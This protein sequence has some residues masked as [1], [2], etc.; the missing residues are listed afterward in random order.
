MQFNDE[1][2]MSFHWARR[3][4]DIYKRLTH[5]LEVAPNYSLY[6]AFKEHHNIDYYKLNISQD[7]PTDVAEDIC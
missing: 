3:N 4:T 5:L 2:P 7:E 1:I 6:H